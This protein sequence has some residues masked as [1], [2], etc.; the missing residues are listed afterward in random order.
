M[1]SGYMPVTFPLNYG[2]SGDVRGNRDRGVMVGNER[3]NTRRVGAA[4]VTLAAAMTLGASPAEAGT[5]ASLGVEASAA[6]A[7]QKLTITDTGP[8]I[9]DAGDRVWVSGTAT[10]GLKQRSV[11]LQQKVGSSWKAVGKSRVKSNGTFRVGGTAS[12]GGF[13]IPFRVKA[14]KAGAKP[15]VTSSRSKFTV[16]DWY[17]LTSLTPVTSPEVNARSVNFEKVGSVNVDG[18]AYGS[19]WA[20]RYS[21]DGFDGLESGQGTFELTTGCTTFTSTIGVNDGAGANASWQFLVYLDGNETN[22]EYKTKGESEEIEVDVTAVN[23]LRLANNRLT[24]PVG[25]ESYAG[26][27]VWA[28]GRIKCAGRP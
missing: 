5:A 27:A 26:D 9:V 19:S 15:A 16:Y 2:A 8:V 13:E 21:A 14:V 22:Y 24:G 6:Q 11:V 12:R 10:A 17:P 28:G 25:D 20:S 7:K 18:Q 3:V 23:R 1:R 4:A